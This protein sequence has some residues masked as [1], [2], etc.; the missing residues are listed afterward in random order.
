MDGVRQRRTGS[1]GDDHEQGIRDISLCA[2]A[3]SVQTSDR[4][5]RPANE[6]IRLRPNQPRFTEDPSPELRHS[7]LPARLGSHYAV[8]RN[9]EHSP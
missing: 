3:G 5:G 7:R 4:L 2:I 9:L 8:S 6:L 1:I